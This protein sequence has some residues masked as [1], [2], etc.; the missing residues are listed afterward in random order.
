LE[1]GTTWIKR[2]LDIDGEAAGDESGIA[3]SI[4]NNSNTVAIGAVINN[5]AGLNTEGGHIRI[6]DSN[7]LNSTWDQRG[8]D[9]DGETA[10]DHFGHSINMSTDGNSVVAGAVGNDGNGVDAGHVRIYDWNGTAWIQEGADIDGESVD[11]QSGYSV[12]LSANG[13]VVAVGAIGNDGNGLNAGHVRVYS[14]KGIYGYA[15]YDFTQN[16]IKDLNDLALERRT[17]LINPGNIIVQSNSSGSWF[18]DSLPIG[19]YTI[20]VDTS[21]TNWQVT[22]P[23]TQAF[24]ISNPDALNHA[25]DFGF[26]SNSSCT[27]PNVS[28]YAPFLRRGFSNQ[29]IYVQACNSQLA[30]G[31]IDSAYMIVE[32]N[33]SLSVNSASLP[34]TP[35]GNN[36]YRIYLTDTLYP[37][38]CIDFQLSCTVNLTTALNSTLCMEA[39]LYPVDSCALDDNPNP[40][41][42][43]TISPCNLPWDR[44]SIMV[45]GSCLGD[46]VRFVVHNT[47]YIGSGDMDCLSPIRIY[48]DGQFIILDSIQLV[49]GDSSV[50]VLYGNGQTWRLEAD[51]HPLHPGNSH[52]NSTIENCGTGNW[53]PGLVNILPQDDADPINDIYCGL[54]T[55]SYDPNDKRGF[56]L[57]VG[58]NHN[59]SPNQDIDYV[60]RFQNTGTDTAFTIIIRD[61]LSTDLDIFSIRSGISSNDYHFRIYGPR[62]LE[63]RFDNIMLPDSNVNEPASNGFVSFKV[64][65]KPDLVPATTIENTASIYFDYNAPIFTNTSW[66]TIY[67]G[68]VITNQDKI[69]LEEN[70]NIK[71]YPNPTTGIIYIDKSNK[72]TILISVLDNLGRTVLTQQSREVITNLNINNLPKGIYYI[73]INNGKKLKTIKIVKS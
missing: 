61:T 14:S 50:Y 60:I 23:I 52:P 67:E 45:E 3:V 35:L 25:P 4:S 7:S 5:N 59:I 71:V 37:N 36:Q 8:A 65:Q 42:D 6:Y 41:P 33:N 70:L 40:Y 44:S 48:L 11:D 18:V 30:T 55:G 10:Y 28:I 15:Y 54:V 9:I 39:K 56:P 24:T 58:N 46:S 51:Q 69:E 64:G 63:W 47:G 27:D 73:S 53:T 57:G 26:I 72:E 1:Y 17:F 49:G 43:S 12:S 66:H 22:C 68:F 29:I 21:S 34:Y 32:L 2:G 20:T 31:V 16:C 13:N 38:Q 62:V 19:N